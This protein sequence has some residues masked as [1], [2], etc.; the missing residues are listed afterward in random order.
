MCH[1]PLLPQNTMSFPELKKM[2]N[3]GEYK[4]KSPSQ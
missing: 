4:Y 1:V 3:E 2:K